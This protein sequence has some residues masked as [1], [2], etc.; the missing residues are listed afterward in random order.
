MVEGVGP[1]VRHSVAWAGART[2]KSISVEMHS[3][4]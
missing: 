1:S 3:H 2:R 4:N